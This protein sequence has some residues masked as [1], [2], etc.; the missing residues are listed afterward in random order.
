MFSDPFHSQGAWKSRTFPGRAIFSVQRSVSA[1][2]FSFQQFNSFLPSVL[3]SPQNVFQSHSWFMYCCPCVQVVVFLQQILFSQQTSTT[4]FS[5]SFSSKQLRFRQLRLLYEHGSKSDW[6]KMRAKSGGTNQ[7]WDISIRQIHFLTEDGS[8]KRSNF[9]KTHWRESISGSFLW[10][11][12]S[13]LCHEMPVSLT[14]SK[15]ELHS[16]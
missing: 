11:Q 5:F 16:Q 9:S 12:T 14:I 7:N 15:L 10:E 1:Q 3:L 4:A 13:W 2:S 8:A 6:F